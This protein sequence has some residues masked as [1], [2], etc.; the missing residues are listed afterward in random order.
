MAT[1]AQVFP[2]TPEIRPGRQTRGGTDDVFHLRALPGEDVYLYVKRF[3][4][5]GVVRQADPGAGQA[6]WRAICGSGIAALLL[7]ALLLP[8]GYRLLAGY[9][10]SQLKQERELAIRELKALEFEEAR[11][12][13]IERMYEL[14]KQHRMAP[15]AADQLI[16]SQPQDAVAQVQRPASR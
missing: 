12:L 4:N 14:A 1:A 3:D 9:Q 13:R 10:L 8:G 5:T 7:I 6:A 16:Y 15:P 11:Y 2:V